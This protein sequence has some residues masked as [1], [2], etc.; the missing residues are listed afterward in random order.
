L[1]TRNNKQAVG[2]ILYYNGECTL[3]RHAC[4]YAPAYAFAYQD[5]SYLYLENLGTWRTDSHF[6]LKAAFTSHK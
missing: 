5:T 1:E 3:I 6:T 4:A 2:R